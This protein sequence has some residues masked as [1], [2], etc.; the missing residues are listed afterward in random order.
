SFWRLQAELLVA[1]K[2]PRKAIQSAFKVRELNPTDP[3]SE[4]L[5]SYCYSAAGDI[6][7]ADRAKERA[8]VLAL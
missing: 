1:K 2:E 7:S 6:I 5:L 4:L 8:R 3:I